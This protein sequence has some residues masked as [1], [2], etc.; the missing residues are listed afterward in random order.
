[1][2]IFGLAN[3]IIQG[4]WFSKLIETLGAKKVFLCGMASFAGICAIFP[5]ISWTARREGGV[6]SRGWL[7]I[8]TQ[9]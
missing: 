7:L 2:A 8:V 5:I 4:L 1:M 9:L 6:T 3:G